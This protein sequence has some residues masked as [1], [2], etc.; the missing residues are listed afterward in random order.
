MKITRVVSWQSKFCVFLSCIFYMIVIFSIPDS[1][2][3]R[4]TPYDKFCYLCLSVWGIANSCAISMA[5]RFGMLAMFGAASIL[6]MLTHKF[7]LM[8]LIFKIKPLNWLVVQE[9]LVTPILS[10]VIILLA[11]LAI[12]YAFDRLM[13]RWIP[14]AIG[15]TGVNA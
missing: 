14:W 3:D 4:I 15:T 12:C 1:L 10:I 8:A 11:S 9:V 6:I 2:F 13:H 5:M 7:V